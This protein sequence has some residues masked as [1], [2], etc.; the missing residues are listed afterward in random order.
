LRREHVAIALRLV[1]RCLVLGR[2]TPDAR[3]FIGVLLADAPSCRFFGVRCRSTP[4]LS[5][6]EACA[7]SPHGV[8]TDD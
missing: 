2:L 4:T 5:G 7:S 8:L 6:D 3:V 1:K